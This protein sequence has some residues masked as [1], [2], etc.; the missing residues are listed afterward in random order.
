LQHTIIFE[1]YN[2]HTGGCWVT[3][4]SRVLNE[5]LACKLRLCCCQDTR[6]TFSVQS[7]LPVD[8][9]LHQPDLIGLYV[10]CCFIIY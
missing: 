8:S 5:H 2:T 4:V 9:F 1:H 7:L 6:V 10:C 3:V